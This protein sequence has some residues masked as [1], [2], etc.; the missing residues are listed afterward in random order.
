MSMLVRKGTMVRKKRGQSLRRAASPKPA[1]PEH[2]KF[3]V[4]DQ[5]TL[6]TPTRAYQGSYSTLDDEKSLCR[7]TSDFSDGDQYGNGGSGSYGSIFHQLQEVNEE[8]EDPCEFLGRAF[9]IIWNS[10]LMTTFLVS[11]TGLPIAMIVIGGSHRV[12]CPREPKVPIYLLVGGGFGLLKMLLLLWRQK[13]SRDYE[14]LDDCV[15]DDADDI[16]MSRS[17]RFSGY[18]LTIFLLSWFIL[19]NVWIFQ[20]WKPNF[21]QPLHEPMNW[22]NETVYMFSV[23]QIFACYGLMGFCVL[24][25]LILLIAY[26]VLKLRVKPSQQK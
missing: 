15:D 21:V 18:I 8:C 5:S 17:T 12:D 6:R 9:D 3:R 10:W 7:S 16:V 2:G 22:C 14:R 26:A 24:E 1:D 13:K 11:L 20:V 23:Y 25:L 19:G 4:T